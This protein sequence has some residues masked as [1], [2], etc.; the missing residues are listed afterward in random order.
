M[1]SFTQ[2]K[3]FLNALKTAMDSFKVKYNDAKNNL[4]IWKD[5]SSDSAKYSSFFNDASTAGTLAAS[6]VPLAN[7][8]AV[9]NMA[10]I[11]GS[12]TDLSS[13]VTST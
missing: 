9:G 8:A 12:C 4:Q 10:A 7:P 2:L 6:G 11:E 13:T 1:P 5:A 3:A